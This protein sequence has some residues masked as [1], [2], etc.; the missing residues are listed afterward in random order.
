M[1]TLTFDKICELVIRVDCVQTNRT[2]FLVYV[3]QTIEIR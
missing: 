1:H 3:N 2:I